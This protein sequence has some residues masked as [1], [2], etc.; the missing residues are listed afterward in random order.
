MS[1]SQSST[2]S[3][4]GRNYE[5]YF[6]SSSPGRAFADTQ[7]PGACE[8]EHGAVQFNFDKIVGTV[9][10]A[11][12]L[13]LDSGFV[14]AGSLARSKRQNSQM[15]T[16]TSLPETPAP[17]QNPFRQ[18]RSQLLPT[19]QLFRATQFSSAVKV[20]SPTSSRPSPAEFPHNNRNS[21][22]LVISSPLKDRGLRSSPATVIPSSPQVVPASRPSRLRELPSSPDNT[23]STGDP[24]IPESSNDELPRKRSP[25]EPMAAYEP[26]QKSQE[27]RSS[28]V[29]SDP[30]SNSDKDV[31]DEEDDVEIARR[32]RAKFK[33]AAGL[34]SLS[35]INVARPP[36]PLTGKLSAAKSREKISEA[37][38]YIAQCHGTNLAATDSDGTDVV[39][40]SQVKDS[41]PELLPVPALVN[42]PI[43]DDQEPTQSDNREQLDNV[44]DQISAPAPEITIPRTSSG[45]QLVR[46]KPVTA[47]PY[48]G[49][50]VPETSQN[51][52]QPANVEN[53]VLGSEDA[54]Q[55][56]RSSPP[57]FS[58]RATRAKAASQQGARPL[59]T[60]SSL[61]NLASTPVVS[62]TSATNST[63][64]VSPMDTS[65]V[66]NSSPA[67]RQKVL[68]PKKSTESLR[69]SSRLM[70]RVSSSPDELA[71]SATPAFEQSLRIARIPASRS[72]SRSGRSAA[73]PPMTQGRAKLF[74]GMAFAISFQSK[75]PGESNDT[76]SARMDLSAT[77]VRRITQAG[78]RVLE[79]GFDELFDI[80]PASA[81]SASSP[82][83]Q[84][85]S[86]ITLTA[87]GRMTG[88]TA[89]IADGH[90][91]K[92]KYM[93][94]LAL[95]LPCIAAR[96]VT[97]CLD[98][99][100][101]VD[102]S[103][104]LLCAGESSFLGNAIRSRSLTPY[105]PLTARLADIIRQRSRF[106]E[107]NKILAVVKKAGENKKM[108]YVFL[109][110]ILGATLTRVYNV[111]EARAQVKA[112]EDSGWP[113][114]WIYVDGK[115]IEKAIFSAAPSSAN[116]KRKRASM[117]IDN[118]A[119]PRLKKIRTLND[120][121]VIQSLILG[122][123]IE[124][125]E[126]EE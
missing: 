20:A 69:H 109:A 74:E 51:R 103:P 7:A 9:H 99:N 122:R 110:R 14:D 22:N 98:R 4:T 26:R 97:V 36:R 5:R 125:G 75:K 27:R 63:A 83:T 3:N 106:L 87:A 115:A 94:A 66:A 60:S 119:G 72:V 62:P 64:A 58:K 104:Y 73:K 91:R 16:E 84:A 95:G 19:S 112:A 28:E 65:T 13:Q 67:R 43:V 38:A 81:S 35:G 117:G 85:D 45:G 47:V 56:F 89:L 126:L 118:D 10:D 123:L 77:V 113:F 42:H 79:N 33:Q 88:F 57:T 93:Q 120:E 53:E 30:I 49:E 25:P 21:P 1:S 15:Q 71:M 59:S 37:D 24:V 54:T 90:S 107:G 105:D 82:D 31:E 76:F 114:D 6:N 80:R 61:S 8:D 11:E 68:N 102:W 111:E 44:V 40:D 46:E 18:N 32:L 41:E 78:G 17:P 96:W 86:E 48:N 116:K 12:L 50:Q 100:E 34:K 52:V 2:Q 55:N 121:L 70:K 101:L 23:A 39:K 124:E 108:A 29:R 92:V